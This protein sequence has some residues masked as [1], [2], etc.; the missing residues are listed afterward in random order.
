MDI[1][2]YFCYLLG[3]VV[4]SVYHVQLYVIVNILKSIDSVI[5]YIIEDELS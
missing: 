2:K 1:D 5:M 3:I 4:N